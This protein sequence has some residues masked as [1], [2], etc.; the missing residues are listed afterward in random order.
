MEQSKVRINTD[1]TGPVTGQE[2]VR[3]ANHVNGLP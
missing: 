1:T 3:T 2:L